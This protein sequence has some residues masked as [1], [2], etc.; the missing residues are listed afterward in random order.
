MLD[1]ITQL[2][3]FSQLCDEKFGDYS[4]SFSRLLQALEEIRQVTKSLL[5]K[6]RETE[7]DPVQETPEEGASGEASAEGSGEAGTVAAGPSVNL[8]AF[9]G[10]EGGA[11]KALIESAVEAATQLRR[12]D[13]T[14]PGPYLMLRGLRFGE[15]RAAAARGEMKMLEAPPTEL[16]RQLRVYAL[17][18]RWKELLE[19]TE[20]SLALPASRAWMDLHRMT[21]EALI[22]LGDDYAPVVDAIRSLVRA[23]VRDVPEIRNA[24][25][26][27]DT[28]A[29]NPQT[30][31]WLD[32]LQ[33]DPPQLADSAEGDDVPQIAAAQAKGTPLP[34]R[35]KMT[36]PFRTALE[37]LRRGDKSKALEIMRNEIESQPSGRGK[38]LREIQVAELCVQANAKEIAQPILE[39]I[40]AK[41]EEFRLTQWEDRAVVVQALAAIYLYHE[42][43][44]DSD[45]DRNAIFQQICRLD[46]VRALGLRS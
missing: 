11:R 36:D 14:N 7:P 38:F 5:D 16:R 34:W 45:R 35:R 24:I 12:L 27:D 8:S 46:P 19:L 26:M 41:M 1:I 9:S 22:G 39:Q 25:L 29:A 6:K 23:L 21:S 44:I 3:D 40:K 43:T 2:K 37:A 32:E 17:D 20:A 31:A 10:T 18:Q 13:P 33:D 42:E 30:Q 4:P 15:L 28:P